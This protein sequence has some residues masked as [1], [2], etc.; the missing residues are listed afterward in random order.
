MEKV[1]TKKINLGTVEV[2]LACNG[3][4]EGLVLQRDL[5]DNEAL[6]VF[7]KLLGYNAHLWLDDCYNA[8]ERRDFRKRLTE[9]V[10][11]MLKGEVEEHWFNNEYAPDCYDEPIPV[12][13][14]LPVIAYLKKK[15]IIK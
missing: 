2:K 4:A 3:Y 6:Y 11:G 8:E 12:M 10:N 7:D 14:F 13:L 1:K 5:T 9:D 15:K